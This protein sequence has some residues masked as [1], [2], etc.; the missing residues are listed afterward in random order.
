M[1]SLSHVRTLAAKA[2]DL[3]RYG[4]D[5]SPSSL[6]GHA[7]DLRGAIAS[8]MSEIVDANREEIDEAYRLANTLEA[9]ADLE[10]EDWRTT[11]AD[12]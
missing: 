6:R 2:H 9:D 10:E 4:G 3:I 8:L 12:L 1:N 5:S 11:D 7:R